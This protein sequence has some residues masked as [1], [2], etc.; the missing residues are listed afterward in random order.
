MKRTKRN[1]GMAGN[2]L[3]ALAH[4]RGSYFT[5]TP[6]DDVW[7]PT[8]LERKVRFLD[9][10]HHLSIVFS[11]AER[12]D[13][14]GKSL[15]PFASTRFDGDR[16]ITSRELQP[17]RGKSEEY[18]I[19]ILTAVMRR[20]LLAIFMESWMLGTE[21]MFMWYLGAVA[22]EVGFI[23]EALV[24]LREA[25]HYR[26]VEERGR[27][28][29]FKRRVDYRQRQ[30][31]DFHRVLVRLHPEVRSILETANAEGFVADAI[32]GSSAT[33]R[34]V[35]RALCLVAGVYGWGTAKTVLWKSVR[36]AG[37]ILLLPR[38]HETPSGLGR[39]EEASK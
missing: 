9:T 14:R 21:E 31:M 13:A 3:R 36:R 25:E 19:N 22:G 27:L 18:F 8:N 29:D 11:N 39:V 15:K 35:A 37:G 30:L 5:F 16:R 38:S 2:A 26:V 6:D 1:V 12:I 7:E 4:V 17:I 28:I 34:D 23:G 24:R 33:M 32:V 10:N 20:D